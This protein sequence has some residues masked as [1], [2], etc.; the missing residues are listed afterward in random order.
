MLFVLA[1]LPK[2]MTTHF[3]KQCF[4]CFFH[5]TDILNFLVDYYNVQTKTAIKLD[6]RRKYNLFNCK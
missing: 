6:D 3:V 5:L 2:L 1:V 4:G